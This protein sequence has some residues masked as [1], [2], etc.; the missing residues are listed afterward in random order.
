MKKIISIVLCAIMVIPLALSIS[1][2]AREFLNNGN[3]FIN[4]DTYVLGDADGDGEQNGK[5]ALAIKAT[6]AGLEGYSLIEDAADFNGDGVVDAKDSYL[7]KTCLS[8][9]N[10]F[11]VL[12]GEHQIYSLTIGGNPIGEYSILLPEGCDP[13]RDNAH[14]AAEELQTYIEVATGVRLEIYYGVSPTEHVI[15]FYQFYPDTPENLEMGLRLENYKYTVTDGDLCIYGSLRGNMYAVYEILEDYLGYRFV[16]GEYTFI[17][18]SRTV[19]IPEGC[20]AFFAPRL[21]YRRVRHT[22]GDDYYDMLNY[23]YP[24]RLNGVTDFSSTR[25]GAWT[26][27]HYTGVHSFKYL[28]QMAT[29]IMPDES[30]GDLNARYKYKFDTGEIK[31]WAS[32]QPCASNKK[33]YETLFTGLVQLS[34]WLLSWGEVHVF[35]C[36]E[37][38]GISV[39][40]FSNEDN[41][42]YCTCRTCNKTAKAEG[43]SG[44][45][46]QM[47][48]KAARDIQEYFP[49]LKIAMILYDHTVPSTVRPDS[50]MVINY[51]GNGCNNHPLGSGGC[52]DNVTYLGD[53]NKTDEYAMR[54]WGEICDEAGC[55][56]WSF[57]YPVNYHYYLSPCPNIFN[58][59][60][61]FSFMVNECGFDGLYYEGGGEE[62]Q[63]EYLK[64]YL[65]SRFMCDPDMTMDEYIGYMKEFLYIWYGDGYEYIYEFILLQNEAGDAAGCFINNH[66][67]PWDLYSIY[68]YRE[69]YEE[70]RAL[71]IKALEASEREECKIRIETLIAGCEFMGL[72]AVHTAWYTEGTEESRALYEERYTALM[73]F[74]YENGI[75][76]SR[77]YEAPTEI[78]FDVNPVVQFYET[79]SWY[80]ADGYIPK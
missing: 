3:E 65:A 50:H 39:M 7:M 17:Y 10:S 29:G 21:N 11:E 49:G 15:R 60:Y 18:K 67:R 9:T 16:N 62:Y 6:V 32:W 51:C 38:Y 27:V 73:N 52:G 47:A 22:F 76:V 20:D 80:W 40:A 56:L 43:Y 5:D 12:E 66:D 2:S 35:R 46:L 58:L 13:D 14:Y 70:M 33:E 74:I 37:E 4:D 44:L 42:N 54:A 68:Y 8:G 23:H 61:D 1:V 26:G 24:R 34:E 71:L 41:G 77:F 36:Y 63:F 64:A 48:N 25:M 79:G 55:E 19:D 45:Y 30:Y 28:W 78:V 57:Y 53:S 72:S 69:H 59:Y 75:K 31:D